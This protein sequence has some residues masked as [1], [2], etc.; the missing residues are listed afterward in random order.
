[1]AGLRLGFVA[2]T[3]ELLEKISD[4]L[5]PWSINGPAQHI[6]TKALADDNWQQK[7]RLH[8]TQSSKRLVSLLARYFD[9]K[10]INATDLFVTINTAKAKQIYSQL[11]VHK[12]YIRLCDE[13]DSI[14]FSIPKDDELNK[15]AH[16]FNH[17]SAILVDI[18]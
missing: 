3:P 16:A 10:N 5:G 13:E 6:V 11:L 12:I 15:L 9:L 4:K 1:M 18:V 8:L 7:Q 2:S 14:R 17:L